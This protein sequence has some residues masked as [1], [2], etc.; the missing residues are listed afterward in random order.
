MW[1]RTRVDKLPWI[2]VAAFILLGPAAFGQDIEPNDTP[3]GATL[4]SL[5]FMSG[6][7]TISGATD[8]DFYKFNLRAGQEVTVWVQAVSQGSDLAPIVA[9]YDG[10]G[11]L[12]EYNDKEFNLGRNRA[13]DDPIVYLK[14]P[15]TGT[16]Y[17]SVSAATT[18]RN[19][20]VEGSGTAG[21]Y[22]IYLFTT[23]DGVYIGDR[24]EPN[25]TQESAT[26]VSL[27]FDTY[28]AHLLYFGDIDWYKLAARRGDRITLDVDALEHKGHEGWELIVRARVG[29]FDESGKLLAESEANK[30]PDSGFTDDPALSFEVPRDGNYYVA[31]TVY[32]NTQY[33]TA[34]TNGQFRADP[35]VSSAK[36]DLGYYELHIHAVHDLWFPQIANGSFGGVY[37][38]TTLL[39]VNYSD[40]PASGSVTFYNSDGAPLLSTFVQGQAPSDTAFFTI[41]PHGNWVVR[42][43]GAG[44]GASG[45][46]VLRSSVPMG[47]SAVFSQHEAGGALM[48]EAGVVAATGMDFFTFPVDVTG[49]FNTGVAVANLGNARPVSLYFKLLDTA[50]QTVSTRTISLAPGHHMSTFVSGAGQLFP[51]VTNFRGSLQVFADSP[52]PAVAL[53]S[54]PRTLTTLPAT[55]INQA[56]QPVTLYFPQVVTGKANGSYRSTII[57]TNPGY[58]PAAGNLRFTRGSGAPMPVNLEGRLAA[59]HNFTLPP[60]ST[61]FLEASASGALETG[62]ATLTADHGVGGV[63]IYAQHDAA[64]GRLET[65]VGVAAADPYSKFCLFVEYEEGYNTGIAVANVSS[66]AAE[67]EYRLK[68]ASGPEA[69]L[70]KGPVSLEPGAQRADLISGTN[71]IF[72]GFE[73][74]GNLEIRASHP[75]PAVA[76]RISAT[77]MTALPVIRIP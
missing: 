7:G 59:S 55:S 72:P 69:L 68:P 46:A 27:P 9:L 64:T 2:A 5:P 35:Y 47:G 11:N 61:A 24:Y 23:F 70:E 21:P 4:L 67:L 66:D 17:A 58:F 63:I 20:P 32:H 15:A 74:N 43:D 57:L 73:G 36:N 12:L 40:L 38:T 10:A 31:V 42:T 56:F 71:Q 53:R 6:G 14:V 18:F 51:T 37:F 52:V 30:D 28:G 13:E 3:Q 34:F 50:G 44:P 54:S 29:L 41:P 33:S 39:L 26:A 76:L 22:Y 19:K 65:E 49:E 60:L 16:Y 45:Y 1:S 25:D 48:T 8:I 62:Y 77:G 75:V